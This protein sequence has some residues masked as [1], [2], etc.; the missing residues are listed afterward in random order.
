MFS[1]KNRSKCNMRFHSTHVQSPLRQVRY[2]SLVVSWNRWECISRIVTDTMTFSDPLILF[3][4]W[5]SLMQTIPFA[6]SKTSSMLSELSSVTKSMDTV[7]STTLRK[8]SGRLLL[9][10]V[11]QGQ[12]SLSA[13]SRTTTSL[14]LVEELTKRELSTLSK[15]MTFQETCGRRLQVLKWTRRI[16]CHLTWDWHT[17]SLTT[18]LFFLVGRALLLSISSTAASYSTSRRWKSR[19]GVVL[20]TLAHS[21]THLLCSTTIFTPMAMTSTCTSTTSLSRSGLSFQSQA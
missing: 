10:C 1:R 9:K 12:V 4:T 7:K 3:R 2:T 20:L 5:F 11:C 8:T 6:P 18:R 13:L 19:R 16:G 15:C 17:R 21:W 14:H